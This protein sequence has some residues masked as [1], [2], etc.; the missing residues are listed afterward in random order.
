MTIREALLALFDWLDETFL[1]LFNWLDETINSVLDLPV[2]Q[3]LEVLSALLGVIIAA[4]L[5]YIIFC[6]VCD[7]ISNLVVRY[8]EKQ[9]ILRRRGPVTS[10]RFNVLN[11]L[12]VKMRARA[13][14]WWS[15]FWNLDLVDKP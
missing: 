2:S 4:W 6:L 15:D 3:V 12:I 9:T 8:I 10:T 14:S 7:T 1:A 11:T 5:M 13:R